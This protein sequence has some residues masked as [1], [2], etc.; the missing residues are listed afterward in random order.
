M[1]AH[2][3]SLSV[4]YGVIRGKA[5]GAWRAFHRSQRR[6]SP[7][8]RIRTTMLAA[9]PLTGPDRS[10]RMT[11]TALPMTAA[12]RLTTKK[13]IKRTSRLLPIQRKSDG[14]DVA[15]SMYHAHAT[16]AVGHR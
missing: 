8:Q 14:N 6:M 13:R 9:T 12:G 1:T 7:Y 4:T 15:A 3:Y 11:S 5:E 2:E 10:I 16:N